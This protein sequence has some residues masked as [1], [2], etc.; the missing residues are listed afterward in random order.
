MTIACKKRL[1]ERVR[2]AWPLS[3]WRPVDVVELDERSWNV[4]YRHWGTGEVMSCGLLK[5]ELKRA[6]ANMA[7]WEV[8]GTAGCA[9]RRS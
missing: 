7:V 4:T 5:S 9:H 3:E 2:R 8:A 6:E 1:V